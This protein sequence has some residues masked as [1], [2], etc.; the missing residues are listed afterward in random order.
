VTEDRWRKRYEEKL[1][2]VDVKD[3]ADY[4]KRVF[5]YQ[6]E[7][8]LQR[9]VQQDQIFPKGKQLREGLVNAKDKPHAFFAQGTSS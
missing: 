8:D 9:V 1:K 2:A 5:A 7:S 6:D 3:I 4:E